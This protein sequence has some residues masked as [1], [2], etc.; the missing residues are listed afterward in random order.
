MHQL[1]HR[2]RVPVWHIG[3]N[4]CGLTLSYCICESIDSRYSSLRL[5]SDGIGA[6]WRGR[7][8][9]PW[10]HS[11]VH[12]H[13]LTFKQNRPRR[14]GSSRSRKL[15]LAALPDTSYRYRKRAGYLANTT[16]CKRMFLASDE[17]FLQIALTGCLTSRKR[18]ALPSSAQRAAA[19]QQWECLVDPPDASH[20]LLEKAFKITASGSA[21]GEGL[22]SPG[23]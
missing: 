12:W 4:R 18:D 14:R 8:Q 7:L 17:C 22:E 5:T 6:A 3:Q 13:H 11:T 2:T 15:I 1:I 10:P 21:G 23:Q 16:V 20:F 9:H 19:L